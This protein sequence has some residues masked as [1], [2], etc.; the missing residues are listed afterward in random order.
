MKSRTW[1]V[2]ALKRWLVAWVTSLP[3]SIGRWWHPATFPI[4][5]LHYF[6]A[7]SCTVVCRMCYLF[8]FIVDYFVLLT[9]SKFGVV[10]NDVRIL[11]TSSSGNWSNRL[12]FWSSPHRTCG[13]SA[14]RIYKENVCVC[15][16]AVMRAAVRHSWVTWRSR[17]NRDETEE[18]KMEEVEFTH[19]LLFFLCHP[20]RSRRRFQTRLSVK[21]FLEWS[22][23]PYRS[24]L[25]LVLRPHQFC[26]IAQNTIAVLFHSY[27]SLDPIFRRCEPFCPFFFLSANASANRKHWTIKDFTPFNAAP[28]SRFLSK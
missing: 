28:I 21:T 16:R 20:N 15:V 9:V 11:V 25:I 8:D 7:P 27:R 22:S 24:I 13:Q 2:K 23:W 12:F 10:I 5:S 18:K 14:S 3:Q 4:V 17:G 19:L 6:N 1:E 26:T